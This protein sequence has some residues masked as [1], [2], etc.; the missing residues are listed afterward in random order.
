MM[1]CFH[2]SVVSTVSVLPEPL[3]G[4]MA[5]REYLKGIVL[6]FPDVR[7]QTPRSFGQGGW[8]CQEYFVSGT[9]LGVLNGPLGPVPPTNR[10]FRIPQ[11]VVYHLEGGK[12]VEVHQYFDMLGAL[13]QLGVLPGGPP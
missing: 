7:V 11:C 13:A 10:R 2:E 4:P 1:R 6:A 12:I 3:K 9:H 5:N 8:V